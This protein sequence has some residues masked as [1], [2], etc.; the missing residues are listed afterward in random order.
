MS[1]KRAE[2]NIVLENRRKF[3]GRH[4]LD[5]NSVIAGELTHDSGIAFVTAKERG[6]GAISTDW[7][8]SVDGLVTDETGLLLLTTHADCAPLIMYDPV[9]KVL[10]QA[11]AGWRGLQAGII[12]RLAE[13]ITTKSGNPPSTLKCWLGPTIGACCYPVSSDVAEQFPGECRNMTNGK[14]RLDLAR[15]VN[16]EL[17]RIGFD[18]ANVTD[19]KICTS[20]D[21][22]FSS[23]RRDGDAVVAMACVSGLKQTTPSESSP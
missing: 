17:L 21:G 7:I 14:I 15:F 6:R 11:H 20:C 19:C 23:F 1:F 16:M 3:L 10:G 18:A 12:E 9:E 2:L 5:Q 13:T 22:D 4:G 8:E